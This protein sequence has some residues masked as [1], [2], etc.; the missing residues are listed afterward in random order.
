MVRDSIKTNY[1]GTKLWV[2]S[3]FFDKCQYICDNLGAVYYIYVQQIKNRKV[4]ALYTTYT[5]N[6]IKV[7]SKRLKFWV[8]QPPVLFTEVP[9]SRPLNSIIWQTTLY[10][11]IKIDFRSLRT[12]RD[13][14]G[15]LCIVYIGN[16]QSKLFFST[17]ILGASFQYLY[18]LGELL[19]CV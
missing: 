19:L 10:R 8:L 17:V 14:L 18:W 11:S 13:V 12:V 16:C 2:L 3:Q 15:W 1:Y 9:K 4:N 5:Y 6:N 7:L